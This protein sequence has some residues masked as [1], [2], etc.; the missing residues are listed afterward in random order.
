MTNPY[1]SEVDMKQSIY[2]LVCEL[3][4]VKEVYRNSDT[5][6]MWRVWADLGYA[7]LIGGKW[8]ISFENFKKAPSTESIRRS[9]QKVQENIPSLKATDPQVR[10]LRGQKEDMKGNFVYHEELFTDLPGRDLQR[11]GEE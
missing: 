7:E 1:H 6:L 11:M 9:R 5:K 4:H 3:L 10:K 2:D 8:Y